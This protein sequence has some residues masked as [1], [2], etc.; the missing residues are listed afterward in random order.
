MKRE[1]LEFVLS[2]IALIIILTL[3]TFTLLLLP[4]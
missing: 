1:T 4:G 3:T 2:G